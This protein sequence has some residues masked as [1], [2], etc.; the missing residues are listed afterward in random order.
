MVV[1]LL[2]VLKSGAAYVPMDPAYPRERLA[3]ML[4]DTAAPV[5]LTQERLTSVLP[6]H[7][8]KLL[9][10]DTQWSTVAAQPTSRLAPLAGPEALAYVI[11]TSGST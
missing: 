1:A 6:P 2:G 10:L 9:C 4:E 11:F 3:W 8:A 7:D 5:I